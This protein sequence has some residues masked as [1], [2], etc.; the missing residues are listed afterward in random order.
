MIRHQAGTATE[1][2]LAADTGTYTLGWA[3]DRW[4]RAKDGERTP[5][6]IETAARHWKAF[7]KHAEIGMLGQVKRWHVVAWRDDLVD[8]GKLA[9]KSINQRVQLVSAILRA[10]WRDAEMVQPDLKAIPLPEPDD[11]G[12]GAWS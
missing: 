2:P 9:P 12:R 1:T 11:S 7:V 4:L 10:G 5:Q 3:Y 6:T 8:E